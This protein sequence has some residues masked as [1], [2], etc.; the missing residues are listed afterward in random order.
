MILSIVTAVTLPSMALLPSAPF[1][2]LT[3]KIR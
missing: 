2:Y 3:Q 1:L